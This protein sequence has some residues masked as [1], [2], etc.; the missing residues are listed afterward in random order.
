MSFLI[1]LVVQSVAGGMALTSPVMILN[2]VTDETGNK[3]VIT[4]CA[5]ATMSAVVT[6]LKSVG[7]QETVL[8]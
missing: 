2:G 6:V 8:R 5:D 4:T 3:T 1:G 7:A